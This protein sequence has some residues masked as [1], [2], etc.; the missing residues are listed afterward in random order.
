MTIE[1]QVEELWSGS[2]GGYLFNLLTDELGDRFIFSER[3][4]ACKAAIKAI[5]E[6]KKEG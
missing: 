1:E 6:S 5:L 3:V 4:A 2:F